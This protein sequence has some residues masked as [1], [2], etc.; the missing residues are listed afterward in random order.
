MQAKITSF[1][2]FFQIQI[3]LPNVNVLS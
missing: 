1:N 3:S 2:A